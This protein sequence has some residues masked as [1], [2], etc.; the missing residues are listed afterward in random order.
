M[1]GQDYRRRISLSMKRWMRRMMAGVLT[2]AALTGMAGAA[3]FTHCADA[4]RDMGLLIGTKNGYELDRAPTRAEAAVMLV[5]LL[6]E[7][8]AAKAQTYEIPFTDVPGWAAPYIGWLY[9]NKLTVGMSS[10]KF[11]TREICNAQQYATFLLR[12]LGYEDGDGYTYATALDY[13]RTLGVVDAVNCDTERFVR[14]HVV[15]MSYTALSRPTQDGDILLEDLADRGSVNAGKASGTLTMFQNLAAYDRA[16]TQ[17][18]SSRTYQLMGSVTD[19]AANKVTCSGTLTMD[20]Q[21]FSAGLWAEDALVMGLYQKDGV[22]YRHVNGKTVRQDAPVPVG[23]PG[24]RIPASAV[25]ALTVQDGRYAFSFVPGVLNR[26]TDGVTVQQADYS[27]D[28]RGGQI[29]RQTG[30]IYID[31]TQGGRTAGYVVELRTALT[32]QGGRVEVLQGMELA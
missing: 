10:T 26:M 16:R 22:F 1:G 21:D 5:R 9:E 11:G 32:G 24:G 3:N 6:G 15:A 19:S 25:A 13:A 12:A 4:L 2:A 23:L 18:G 17:A 8:D 20:G 29:E 27:A 30:R 7:E 14:D 31:M 28:L